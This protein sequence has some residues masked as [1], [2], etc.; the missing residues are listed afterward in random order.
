MELLDVK[1]DFDIA[2]IFATGELVSPQARRIAKG[3]WEITDFLTHE[4]CDHLIDM[5]N[6]VG[7]TDLLH[8]Y[9]P[10]QRDSSRVIGFDRD[11]HLLT[12]IEQR[13]TRDC[14]PERLS[15]KEN[16]IVPYG[17][18]NQIQWLTP[19]E[20]PLGIKINPCFRF[21]HYIKGSAGFDWHRDSQVTFD[22]TTRSNLTMLIYLTSN[23]D[24][25]L[26]FKVPTQ[27]IDNL[28]L[29]VSQ[30]LEL[31]AHKSKSYTIYPAKGSALI[32]DQRYLH[33]AHPLVDSDHKYVLRTDLMCHGQKLDS[34]M[35]PTELKVNQL[36]RQLFRQAQFYELSGQKDVSKLA[37][38][39]YSI[40][41]SL[42]QSPERI[43]SYESVSHLE[44]YLVQMKFDQPVEIGATL[45]LL[46]RSGQAYKF[47]INSDQAK[48]TTLMIIDA[49]KVAGL[50]T[51]LSWTNEVTYEFQSRIFDY[52]MQLK[53]MAI[54]ENQ[55]RNSY[56]HNRHNHKQELNKPL[57]MSSS[58]VD[59]N[60]HLARICKELEL[61]STLVLSD[62]EDED[63]NN[64]EEDESLEEN[65]SSD[66]KK[67]FNSGFELRQF[68]DHRLETYQNVFHDVYSADLSAFSTDMKPNPGLTLSTQFREYDVINCDCSL[69]D[70]D[71]H[72]EEEVTVPS[73]SLRL[74]P[75]VDFK[76]IHVHI[77]SI[78]KDSLSGKLDF[79]ARIVPFNH[80]S[81]NCEG[82]A[83]LRATNTVYQ[84]ATI[85]LT[86]IYD[87]V[88]RRLTIN[89]IPRV[90]I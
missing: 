42:R 16:F 53:E 37:G 41:L 47:K 19:K 68:L 34:L 59:V 51:F 77:E 80:A 31:L 70:A 15:L 7:Y 44:S 61:R 22:Q 81:C 65:E 78:S 56:R 75:N 38:D 50:T 2:N 55:S 62:S 25:K 69:G 27:P 52:Q 64:L 9:E 36:T 72:C 67:T 1:K 73:R 79:I 30:E 40:C 5:T 74:K 48:L 49:I 87:V 14:F 26:E 4:E 28:G 82:S 11:G 90:V 13:L 71:D 32:F 12:A 86:F 43:Q 24:A 46:S 88:N 58:E 17:T 6:Q 60:V 76:D 18:V 29:T 63:D 39:L 23:R 8:Q 57:L 84:T 83:D 89:Y 35:T 10:E 3:I 66:E 85:D 21:H 45:R 54:K 20:D 33:L